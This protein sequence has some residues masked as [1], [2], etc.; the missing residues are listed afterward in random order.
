MWNGWQIAGAILMVGGAVGGLLFWYGGKIEGDKS[1]RE[2]T[3]EIKESIGQS[4]VELE[5][6]QERI[7]EEIILLHEKLDE[8]HI[9]SR[10]ALL[11]K[12]KKTYEVVK[13]YNANFLLKEGY[14]KKGQIGTCFTP[15]WEGVKT[16]KF[17]LA[18][19]VGNL[20]K[21]RISVFFDKHELVLRILTSDGRSETVSLDTTSWKKGRP[22]LIFATW[23]TDKDWV[24]LYAG[25]KGDSPPQ[26]EEKIIHN[27]HFEKLGQLV[28]MGIYF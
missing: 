15:E 5:A 19:I 10:K 25:E 20:E 17:F 7:L 12:A 18:D 3:E 14:E 2:H 21:D 26:I 23:D 11:G 16:R 27:L 6:N 24:K 28:F 9:L 13:N 4:K 1:D 8:R 22:Y